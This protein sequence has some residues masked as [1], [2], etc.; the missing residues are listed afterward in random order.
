MILREKL[1]IFTSYYANRKLDR[2][3]HYLVRTSVGSPR[4]VK[5][6]DLCLELA[7]ERAWIGLAE[8]PYRERYLG[9][10]E[11]LGI[12][13]MTELM[14]ELQKRAAKD[15]KVP[16]LLCYEALHPPQV[17]A[18]QFCHRRLFARW[19]EAKTGQLFPEL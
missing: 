15:G 13:R 17:A 10:L 4:F 16:V 19:Y 7:P 6:D 12:E 14:T 18:G 11:S 5:C 3:R 8:A 1:T 9:K 2:A